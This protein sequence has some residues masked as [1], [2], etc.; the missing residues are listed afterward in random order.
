V[1]E[2]LPKVA[3]NWEHKQVVAPRNAPNDPHKIISL[4]FGR[5]YIIYL[6]AANSEY[7]L[8]MTYLPLFLSLFKSSFS[9][10]LHFGDEH[11]YA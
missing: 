6:T 8:L 9:I 3:K 1:D 10:H 7:D 4:K 2:L 11:I 5:Q